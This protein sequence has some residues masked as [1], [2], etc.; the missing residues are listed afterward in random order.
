MPQVLRRVGY[1][2]RGAAQNM[3]EA[4]AIVAL[5]HI[6]WKV[7]PRIQYPCYQSFDQYIAWEKLRSLDE[8]LTEKIQNRVNTR[9]PLFH[10][11]LTLKALD[12]RLPGSKMIY[13]TKSNRG[14][15]YLD[16]NDPALWEKTGEAEYFSLLT[17]FIGTLPFKQTARMLIMYDTLGHAITPHRDHPKKEICHEFIWFRT[18]FKKP[19]YL[20]NQWTGVKNY[21]ESYSAWFD[22]VNQFHGA[23]AHQGPSFTIRV[24]GIFN[25][26]IRKLIPVP[27]YNLAS[28]P[29][30]WAA[31]SSESM[32]SPNQAH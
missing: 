17:D 25:D 11:S 19:F 28:T 10:T 26:E 7:D 15:S 22:T 18:N 4:A 2:L 23:D 13:L 24:D 29:A 31:T 12:K 32:H 9:D 16:L 14:Y 30:L 27:R 3:T 6:K 5:K 21:V 8:Y 20:L 1:K